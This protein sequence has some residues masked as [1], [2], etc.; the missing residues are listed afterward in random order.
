MAT[1]PS[2]GMNFPNNA[3]I[4]T[5]YSP[6]L[7]SKF[8]AA[9]VCN[10]ITNQHWQGEIKEKGNTVILRQR[11]DISVSPYV[12]NEKTIWTPINDV[13]QKLEIAYAFEA[14]VPLDIVD[15]HEFDINVQP[16]LM[17]EIANRLRIRIETTIL[18][19]VYADAQST[20][21]YNAFGTGTGTGATYSDWDATPT[22]FL[23]KAHELLDMSFA[24]Q[25]DRWLVMHPAMMTRLKQAVPLY[26]LNAGTVQGA[27]QRGF[28]GELEGFKIYTSPFIPGAGT[29]ANPYYAI[30]G[31][32]ESITLATQFT[33][34]EVLPFLI[35]YTGQGLRAVNAFGFK[36]VKPDCLVALQ[37]NIT[38]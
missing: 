30:A 1:I 12:K 32:I 11:P 25:E 35:D 8:Y 13:S 17:D 26:A 4:P 19:S 22:L 2:T 20:I 18:G 16:E 3:F 33:H 6:R 27:L 10:V 28:V 34:F 23:S 5:I 37:V 31:H 15:M 29:V 7:I 14:A 38:A 9:S 21:A 36:T 24:P